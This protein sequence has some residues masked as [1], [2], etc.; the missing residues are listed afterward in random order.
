[1]ASRSQVMFFFLLVA[2]AALP[3]QVRWDQLSPAPSPSAR[4]EPAAAWHEPSQKLLLFGGAISGTGTVSDD[5]WEWCCPSWI[6]KSPLNKPP[7]RNAAGMVYCPTLQENVLFGGVAAGFVKM[8]DMWAWNGTDWRQVPPIGSKIPSPRNSFGFAY[9]ARRERIVLFGGEGVGAFKNDTWTWEAATGWSCPNVATA[10]S[11]RCCVGFAY[12]AKREE[13]V[14]FGGYDGSMVYGDTWTWDCAVWS[15]K[16]PMKSPSARRAMAMT[17]D[18]LRERVVLFGGHDVSAPQNEVWEW[19]GTTWLLRPPTTNPPA[20]RLSTSFTFVPATT[21]CAAQPQCAAHLLLFGGQNV[22]STLG[23]TWTYK[24]VYPASIEFDMPGCG[25]PSLSGRGLPWIGATFE[26]VLEGAP[27]FAPFAVA[28][29]TLPCLNVYLPPFCN[30]TCRLWSNTNVAL[31]S[32]TAN[33]GGCGAVSIP[34]PLSPQLLGAAFK[35]QALVADFGAMPA[36]VA[37]SN[38]LKLTI[39]GR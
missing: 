36:C 15:P 25:T 24:P 14:L 35:S 26:L 28:I 38:S 12:D 32:R 16:S 11:P 17:Y 31:F 22:G 29:G 20:A 4:I 5:T 9:D 7:G 23:D 34:V 39:G 8:Q 10:P 2:P 33:A 21:Q 6:E 30:L 27:P 3:A 13:C 37:L 18:P 1:M 19:D